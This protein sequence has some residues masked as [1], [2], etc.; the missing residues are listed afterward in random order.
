MGLKG[1]V[2]IVTGGAMGIGKAIA[3]RLARDGAAVGILDVNLTKAQEVVAELEEGGTRAFGVQCDVTNYT[4][5]QEAVAAVARNLGAPDILVNN[6]GVDRQQFFLE[7][8]EKLWDW[9]ISVNYKGFL[10]IS[11]VTLPYMVEK[12]GGVI[13]NM[14]SDAG[15]VGNAR[16]VVYSGTKAAVMAS[17]KAMALEFARYGIRVNAVSPGPVQQTELLSGLFEGE[18]GEK[19]ARLVPL[20]RL[21]R[22][23][24]VADVVA[25]FCSEDS[26]YLTGQVLSVDGGLT[27]VD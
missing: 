26:R 5:A 9:M 10:V 8:D 23:E 17:T 15:R 18:I 1:K 14:G 6:A 21:G 3:L 16:E 24:E 27:M 7:T 22:P 2:A 13:V 4:N 19:I 11:H 12:K 25:F 20:R